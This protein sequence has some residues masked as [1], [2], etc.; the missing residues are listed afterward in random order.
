MNYVDGFPYI[1]SSL[2]PWDE[3]YL[4]IIGGHFDV[5]LDSGKKL[6]LSIF[7]S[8]FIREIGLKFFLCWIFLWFSY[9]SNCGFIE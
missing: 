7:A 9:Q 5:F 6:S 2:H 3:T 4:I 8:I 1:K